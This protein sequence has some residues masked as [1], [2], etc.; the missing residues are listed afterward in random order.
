MTEHFAGRFAGMRIL[1]AEDE[2]LVSWALEAT[3][4]SLG[5]VV[6]GPAA[7][8]DQTLKLAASGPL[9]GAVLDVNLRGHR[10]FPVVDRLLAD[11]VP[12]ILLTGYD[13]DAT[14]PESYRALPRLPKPFERDDLVTLMGR[15]FC[16]S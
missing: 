10:V 1:V 16:P 6:V 9:D 15:L 3:L 2:S 5:C 13:S 12:V 14:F 7:R 8:L 4:A 11:G